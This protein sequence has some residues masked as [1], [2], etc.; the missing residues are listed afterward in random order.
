MMR[1]DARRNRER[2]V[3]A[4]REVFAE[5]G[6]GAS[7]NQVAQ[8]AGVGAG[9]LYRHFPTSQDLFVEI[10]QDRG[11]FVA[12]LR[13]LADALEKG[14]PFRILV[15]NVRFTVPSGVTSCIKSLSEETM[16]T[17][18]PSANACLV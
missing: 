6:P 4:A 12:T 1:A 17:L 9:T 5:Q 2:I 8:R 7:L 10:I 15:A 18:P 14:V 11:S 3:A 16:V 13:R